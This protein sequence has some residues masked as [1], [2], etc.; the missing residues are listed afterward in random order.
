MDRTVMVLRMAMAPLFVGPVA[1]VPQPIADIHDAHTQHVVNATAPV[2]PL[3]HPARKV[4]QTP[5]LGVLRRIRTS[6]RESVG[7]VKWLGWNR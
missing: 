5:I 3:P 4:A 7:D 1:S 6:R 2:G